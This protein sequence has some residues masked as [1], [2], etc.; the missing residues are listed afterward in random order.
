[1]NQKTAKLFNAISG[2]K[3]H[4]PYAQRTREDWIN[5]RIPHSKKGPVRRDLKAIREYIREEAKRSK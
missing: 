5:G 1:M 2:H 3:I 4:G